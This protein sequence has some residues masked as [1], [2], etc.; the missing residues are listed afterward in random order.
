MFTRHQ[1]LLLAALTFPALLCAV[2]AGAQNAQNNAQDNARDKRPPETT[3]SAVSPGVPQAPVGHRQ[4][5]A[6]DIPADAQQRTVPGEERS[7]L[8]RDLDRQLRICR[9]C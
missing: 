7:Q 6:S 1:T 9:G 8:D 3:G 4:P 2:G 5:R